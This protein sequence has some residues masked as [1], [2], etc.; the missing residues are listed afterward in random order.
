MKKRLQFYIAITYFFSSELEDITK[1]A[2]FGFLDISLHSDF[3]ELVACEI[4]NNG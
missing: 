1:V 3:A 4:L 2:H